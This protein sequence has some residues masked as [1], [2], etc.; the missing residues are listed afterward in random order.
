MESYDILASLY[1]RHGS[2][3]YIGEPISQLSHALQCAA[4]AQQSRPL[5]HEFIAACLLHDVG[6]L[7][8]LDEKLSR[9]EWGT[10]SHDAIGY[11]FLQQLGFTQRVCDLVHEH[12][13]AKRYLCF[14]DPQYY[15]R[16]SIASKNTLVQQ[17]GIFDANQAA[18]WYAQSHA[19]DAVA[20]RLIDD[21]G[22]S[23]YTL[24]TGN[25]QKE[26]SFYKNVILKSCN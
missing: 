10:K 17:G 20:L 12:A 14:A 24:P 23:V 8:G 4:L 11:R 13:R 2:S 18:A 19:P 7:V 15:E 3:D 16:L 26:F 21:Q 1:D 6:E 22:K 25:M 5:D 9:T